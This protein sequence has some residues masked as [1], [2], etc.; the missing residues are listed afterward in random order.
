MNWLIDLLARLFSTFKA[1]NPVVATAILLFLGV[2]VKTAQD[3]AFLGLFT[4]PDWASEVIQY[5][6]LF[7][8][9]VTGSQTYQYLEGKK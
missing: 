1:K 2:A 4:L 7:L 6:G 8:I 3:G 5:I 9:A